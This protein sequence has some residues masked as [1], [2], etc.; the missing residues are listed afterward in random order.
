M[1]KLKIIT[2]T[3]N[4]HSDSINYGRWSGLDFR[5]FEDMRLNTIYLQLAIL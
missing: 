3:V 1:L 4:V 5:G 2:E